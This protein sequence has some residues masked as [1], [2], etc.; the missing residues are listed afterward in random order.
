MEDVDQ[1]LTEF[2]GLGLN[3]G[4]LIGARKDVVAPWGGSL[5]ALGTGRARDYSIALS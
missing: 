5:T 3:G 2:I 4:E 1:E